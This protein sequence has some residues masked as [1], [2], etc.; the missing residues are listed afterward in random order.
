MASH[1]YKISYY[2]FFLQFMRVGLARRVLQFAL[3][4][5]RVML[6]TK[7]ARQACERNERSVS[8]VY[9]AMHHISADLAY[10]RPVPPRSPLVPELLARVDGDGLLERAPDEQRAAGSRMAALL[11]AFERAIQRSE[12]SPLD[13]AARDRCAVSLLDIQGFH[14]IALHEH[15]P[16][17]GA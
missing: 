11:D 2:W 3:Q 12:H 8:S 16:L 14:L 4:N 6:P 13:K 1:E 10:G 7:A 5:A 17:A 9:Y 15:L